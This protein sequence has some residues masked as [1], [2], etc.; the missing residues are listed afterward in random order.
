MIFKLFKDNKG[1]SQS[2]AVVGVIVLVTATLSVTIPA[3]RS[4]V[5]GMWAT[6]ANFVQGIKGGTDNSG[7]TSPTDSSN[8]GISIGSPTPTPSDGSS[9]VTGGGRGTTIGDPKDNPVEPPVS[10]NT[11]PTTPPANNSQP[12]QGTSPG[13]LTPPPADR[14][15]PITGVESGSNTPGNPVP[16]DPDPT[17]TT[18]GNTS[19]SITSGTSS[20]SSS[21]IQPPTSPIS[22]ISSGST[23]GNPIPRP[24]NPTITPQ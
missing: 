9:P 5:N 15:E 10:D 19:S 20:T 22:G 23:I 14:S 24:T 6:A 1:F 3:A 18:D 16:L 11:S 8:S 12:A 21:A 17:R 13:N 2:V 7:I 4:S